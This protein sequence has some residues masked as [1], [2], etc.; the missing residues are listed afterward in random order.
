MRGDDKSFSAAEAISF[1]VISSTAFKK[2][3]TGFLKMQKQTN[4]I[5]DFVTEPSEFSWRHQ[6]STTFK[7]RLYSNL[8]FPDGSPEFITEHNNL[9]YNALTK[10]F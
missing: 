4:F 10:Q 2:C 3:S 5:L 9:L 1:A 8:P 7:L 6:S